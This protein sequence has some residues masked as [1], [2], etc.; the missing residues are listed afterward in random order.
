MSSDHV[1]VCHP[2]MKYLCH[3]HGYV[4]VGLFFFNDLGV[5]LLSTLVVLT[6]DYFFSTFVTGLGSF[7]MKVPVNGCKSFPCLVYL[8]PGLKKN[9]AVR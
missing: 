2:G 7:D 1:G 5:P 3:K 4:G 8:E 9:Q 6:S